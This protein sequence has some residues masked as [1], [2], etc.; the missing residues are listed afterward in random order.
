MHI[1]CLLFVMLVSACSSP[2]VTARG[3]VTE[4]PTP[5]KQAKPQTMNGTCHAAAPNGGVQAKLDAV[6]A[7]FHK[8]VLVLNRQPNKGETLAE[9]FSASSLIGTLALQ[10]PDGSISVEAVETEED[11]YVDGHSEFITRYRFTAPG[12]EEMAEISIVRSMGG[13]P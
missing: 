6:A 10:L 2:A 7:C 4:P 9:F 8:A 12:H 1:I 13:G 5:S 3:P 11:L